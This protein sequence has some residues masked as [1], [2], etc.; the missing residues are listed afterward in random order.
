MSGASDRKHRL[1]VTGI[2]A[3]LEREHGQARVLAGEERVR[4]AE[5]LGVWHR[6]AVIDI[7]GGRLATVGPHGGGLLIHDL[8]D[9]DCEGPPA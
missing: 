7:G 5:A 3:R 6:C 8:R 1:A 2:V 9:P 4:T